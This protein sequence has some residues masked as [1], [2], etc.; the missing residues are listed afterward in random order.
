[1][2]RKQHDIKPFKKRYKLKKL[3]ISRNLKI[4][5]SDKTL[6]DHSYYYLINGYSKIFINS[7]KNGIPDYTNASIQDFVHMDSFDFEV[8][9]K[10]LK[11]ILK[12]ENRIKNQVFY[13]FASFYGD[14]DYLVPSNFDTYG[15]VSKQRNVYDLISRL[16]K[17]ISSNC[18]N[19]KERNHPAFYHYLTKY[20]NIPPWVIKLEI[21]LGEL[22]KFYSNLKPKLRQII[23][24]KYKVK[25]N[26]LRTILYFLS[27]IRNKC[28][29]NERLFD[30]ISIVKLRKNRFH[31]YFKKSK[32]DDFFSIII[33]LKTLMKKEDF[34]DLYEYIEN[35][36]LK[37]RENI[38]EQHFQKVISHMGMPDNWS[39]LL[40][41]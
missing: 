8:R 39:D 30:S 20:H 11:E 34:K 40:Y 24:K 31:S 15:N 6:N 22:S 5:K 32:R 37:L 27:Q 14:V 2:K 28:A 21:S 10:I 13:V 35:E 23:A 12:L 41:I 7:K 18:N 16:N 26:E 3:L 25:E 36:L 29:H 1:M 4:K 17:K 19:E 33:A 38:S 9:T